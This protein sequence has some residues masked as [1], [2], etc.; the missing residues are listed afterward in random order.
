[1]RQAQISVVER[2]WPFCRIDSRFYMLWWI[3]VGRQ[4]YRRVHGHDWHE[5]TGVPLRYFRIFKLWRGA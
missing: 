3:L 5:A 2:L 4:K 1:M